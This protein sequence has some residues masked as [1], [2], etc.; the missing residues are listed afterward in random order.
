M[1]IK[2]DGVS[3]GGPTYYFD[4]LSV[5]L[6]DSVGTDNVILDDK[7]T[8]WDYEGGWNQVAAEGNYLDSLHDTPLQGGA[9]TLGF[10]GT[11]LSLYGALQGPYNASIPIAYFSILDGEIHPVFAAN[12]SKSLILPNST[13]LQNQLIFHT[14]GLPDIGVK[15]YT[16]TVSVPTPPATSTSLTTSISGSASAS[17][18]TSSSSSSTITPTPLASQ[19]HLDYVVYGPS[20]AIA[21][22]PTNTS[23]PSSSAPPAG[24][25]AGGVIGGLAGLALLILA[26]LFW[27][28]RHRKAIAHDAE[29]QDEFKH[30]YGAGATSATTSRPTLA[31][32][33]SSI[34]KG[35]RNNLGEMP[36]LDISAGSP[37]GSS[38]AGRVETS[39]MT[40]PG[41]A[42]TA[43]ET[44]YAAGVMP[45][46]PVREQDGGIRLASGSDVGT[47]VVEV[48]PPSYA[49]Y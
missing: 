34:H 39:T 28:R 27:R 38:T 7:T 41:T 40:G 33:P 25:I 9:A 22:L 16:L 8:Q 23:A 49:R 24:A 11:S 42:D 1:T 14:T 26:F 5:Q 17:S 37:M 43:Y 44:D 4:F 10:H 3:P 12:V 19:W 45:P 29:V 15:Q 21:S 46:R 30:A 32:R 2:A 48:L 35:S 36:V 20:S 31:Q 13:Y 18:T 47:E 6:P